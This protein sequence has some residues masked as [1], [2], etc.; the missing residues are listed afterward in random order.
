[1]VALVDVVSD[2]DRHRLVQ[3]TDLTNALRFYDTEYFKHSAVD[4]PVRGERGHSV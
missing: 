3:A 4:G 1:M 2:A